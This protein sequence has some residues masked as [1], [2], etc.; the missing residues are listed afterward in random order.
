M[1]NFQFEKIYDISIP[2]HEN[3]VVYP[4]NPPIKIETIQSETTKSI[5]SVITFSTHTATHIDSPKHTALSDVGIDKLPLDAFVGKCRVLDFAES[6][7]SVSKA[8][9]EKKDIQ[10]GERILLKTQNSMNGFTEFD[11]EF[12]FLSS[13]GAEY[14]AEIE[15]AL[16]GIDALSI[17]QKG[18][19]DNIPHTALLLKNI[20]ILEGINLQQ[21]EEGEYF[22][23]TPPLRFMGIDGSP[24][25]ALL[26]K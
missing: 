18:S 17:K 4:G 14:L 5:N 19:T 25:R 23:I 1:S 15:I 7:G 20:P 6:Q 22:L 26:L 11:P 16:I 8:D 12:T 10:K 24:A 13:E 21:I 2:L 9:L 3:T